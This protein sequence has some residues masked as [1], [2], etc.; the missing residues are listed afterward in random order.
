MT[1]EPVDAW[2]EK[3]VKITTALGMNPTR[4]RWRLIRWQ[5]RR[6]KAARQRE[7]AVVHVTYKHKTCDA[8]GTVQDRD[9]K[10]CSRCEA[11]LGGRGLQ[12]ARRIG[13][14]PRSI[15]VSVVLALALLAVYVRVLAAAG[16]GIG[17]PSVG[18]LYDF[19]GHW[20]PAISDE[21]WRWV[22]AIFLHAGLWHLAFNLIS[23]G[24]IGP[25]IE[26]LYGR[27]TML[28]LLVATGT[29]AN[30]GSGATGLDGV[31]I[32]ASGGVMGL[33]GIAAGY[34]QRLGT[35]AG[36]ELRNDML[37]WTAYTMV[38]GYFIGADNRAHAFGALVGVAFGYAVSPRQWNARRMLPVRVIL[39]VAGVVAAIG[40][41][42]IIFTREPAPPEEAAE[43]SSPG[44]E[45]YGKICRRFFDGD[46]AGARVEFDKI[47]GSITVRVPHKTE[48]G[49]V[50]R[51]SRN[52][53]E[54]YGTDD[55]VAA[56]CE[57]FLVMR[58]WC[59]SGAVAKLDSTAGLA[60]SCPAVEHTF[61]P[62]PEQPQQRVPR[63]SA[64]A[65]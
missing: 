62:F 28:F 44:Y 51:Q 59:R 50:Y 43:R 33:I 19:G 2:I 35:T 15:S 34:G 49:Y 22:T 52:A 47:A 14:I 3:V 45:R 57:S 29:L 11:K 23:I 25:R 53:A 60:D 16:G 31:G 55:P 9:A 18:L 13:L 48:K 37:R 27:L 54:I 17:S 61:G 39:Q 24:S 65:P 36:R 26:E 41:I 58:E 21:P 42:A 40:A 46:A 1:Q 20:P 56:M 4:T 32:G 7:Q 30:I 5:E 63:G 12:V 6:R 38:F 64:E 8:C 10:T